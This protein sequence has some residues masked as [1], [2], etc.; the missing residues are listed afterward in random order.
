MVV[1]G[2]VYTSFMLDFDQISLLIDGI[3][4]ISVN[5]VGC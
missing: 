3:K 2:S 5:I 4:I 1:E